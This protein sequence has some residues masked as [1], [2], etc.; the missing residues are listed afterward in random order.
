MTTTTTTTTAENQDGLSL[1]K[2]LE[3]TGCSRNAYYYN[4]KKKQDKRELKDT[5]RQLS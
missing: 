1:R 5:K 2:A 3:Y 4:K